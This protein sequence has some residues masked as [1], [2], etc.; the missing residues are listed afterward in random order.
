M[1]S[2]TLHFDGEK[3]RKHTIKMVVPPSWA[4]KPCAKVAKYYAKSFNAAHADKPVDLAKLPAL[5]LPKGKAM[6]ELTKAGIRGA[7]TMKYLNEW[8]KYKASGGLPAVL[9]APEPSAKDLTLRAILEAKGNMDLA[10]RKRV[11]LDGL[12]CSITRPCPWRSRR[13]WPA[14]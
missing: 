7:M 13:P 5:D 8:S 12:S 3:A 9:P 11:L 4:D 14:A 6:M 1:T 2:V 10:S